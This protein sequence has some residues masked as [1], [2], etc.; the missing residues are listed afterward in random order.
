MIMWRSFQIVEFE[1]AVNIFSTCTTN[2]S[3]VSDKLQ[4]VAPSKRPLKLVV[5]RLESGKCTPSNGTAAVAGS[6]QAPSTPP[7]IRRARQKLTGDSEARHIAG[8][9]D[10]TTFQGK[11]LSQLTLSLLLPY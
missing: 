9:A 3:F 11:L 4:H 6:V 5:E 1:I 8:V 7:R 10:Y 2:F